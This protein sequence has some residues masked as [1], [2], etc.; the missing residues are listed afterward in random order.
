MAPLMA[1]EPDT[2]FPSGMVQVFNEREEF[3]ARFYLWAE[4][5]F[6]HHIP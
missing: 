2:P 1:P 3:I 4:Y 5:W 6:E